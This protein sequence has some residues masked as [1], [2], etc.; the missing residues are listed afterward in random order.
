MKNS[1]KLRFKLVLL[2]NRRKVF[3]DGYCS[4]P[5]DDVGEW[6]NDIEEIYD[7]HDD[8]YNIL[9]WH[10]DS[11][12][13]NMNVEILQKIFNSDSLGCDCGSNYCGYNESIH[14]ISGKLCRK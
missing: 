11:S 6:E 8:I 2:V 7:I 3:H 4:D 1:D 10:T 12:N 9:K 14:V 13:E 5:G